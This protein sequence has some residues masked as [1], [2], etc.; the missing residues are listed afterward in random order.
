MAL[1]NSSLLT[2]TA[3]EQRDIL[4]SCNATGVVVV[5]DFYAGS[6]ISC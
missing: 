3:L 2:T 1:K 5:D 6:R 4:F